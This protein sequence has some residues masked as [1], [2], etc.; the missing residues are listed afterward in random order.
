MDHLATKFRLFKVETIGDAYVCA[1]GLPTD[2]PH[3]AEKVATFAVAVS[4]CARHVLSPVDGKPLQLRV[5]IHSGSCASGV[6]G[7]NNPRYCV[8]GDTVSNTRTIHWACMVIA[9]VVSRFFLP[10]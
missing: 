4:H 8:F 6:V 1:A 2:D 9:L 3:H 5:G 7:V 10:G